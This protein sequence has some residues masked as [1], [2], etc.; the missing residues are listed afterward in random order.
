M[1]EGH[2]I[3]RIARDH[4]QEFVGQRLAV[5]SPQGRF[6]VGAKT[7]D[8]RKLESVEAYGK[9]LFYSWS[10]NK[11]VHIHLG[12]YGKYR[13]HRL[14]VPQPQGLVR[15]RVIGERKAFDFNGP[16]AC[17]L[18]SRKERSTLQDRLGPD[19]LRADG[20]PEMAWQ[21]IFRSRS[22]IGTLLLD[23]TTIAGV[24]NVYRSEVLYLLGIH[25][26]TPGN[27]LSR[28]QFDL[29]WSKLQ[30]LLRIGVRYNRIITA[31]PKEVGKS[32]GKMNREERLLVYKRAFCSRCESAIDIWL[33]GGRKIF[34]CP[35]C[36]K[37]A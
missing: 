27:S 26:D 1:P 6:A 24:G 29:L 17:H 32:R 9:H 21:R 18:I 35:K 20:K 22:A 36:Q 31:E 30:T 25:P 3:H 11:M 5:S 23:Q 13:L 19:P 12:L 10:G 4:A 8:G 16:N 2:T 37:A 14:P 33:L 7:L 28:D 15:L 34:A